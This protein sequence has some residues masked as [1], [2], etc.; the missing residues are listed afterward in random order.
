MSKHRNVFPLPAPTNDPRFT[1]GLL[2]DVR[3][4]LRQHGYPA[5]DMTGADLTNLQQALFGFLYDTGAG[6]A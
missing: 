5:E 6:G 4:V 2:V 1:F 3:E